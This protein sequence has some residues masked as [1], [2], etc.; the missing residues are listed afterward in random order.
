MERLKLRR[1]M[2]MAMSEPKKYLWTYELK[3]IVFPAELALPLEK[4]S[5][6]FM[7][8]NLY[9]TDPSPSNV[10]P[11]N[12]TIT[13]NVIVTGENLMKIEPVN[14]YD[15]NNVDVEYTDDGIIINSTGQN[16][17]VTYKFSG[18]I[19]DENY[20]LDLYGNSV[21]NNGD[22]CGISLKHYS[23]GLAFAENALDDAPGQRYFK[24][25]T[26]TE[27]LYV[28]FKTT[29]TATSATTTIGEF[30]LR[31]IDSLDSETPPYEPYGTTYT[32]DFDSRY[33]NLYG[34]CV[35]LVD[36]AVYSNYAIA[37]IDSVDTYINNFAVSYI[38][39]PEEYGEIIDFN[40]VC[41][42]AKF[43]HS[44]NYLNPNN[45]F[46]DNVYTIGKVYDENVGHNR[47]AIVF[48][49]ADAESV[50]DYNTILTQNKEAVMEVAYKFL[51][52]QPFS[53]SQNS[54]VIVPFIGYN[55][56]YA[57]TGGGKISHINVEYWN[58][59]EQP[60]HIDV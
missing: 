27:D 3:H 49:F 57:T 8:T 23:S 56:I 2:M 31:R 35:N 5:V 46:T 43:N 11:I 47:D 59:T 28:T 45:A 54:N 15:S 21:S 42:M 10:N 53:P 1:R 40:S 41:N 39:I 20:V 37:S 38:D 52:P 55:N 16:A 22:A 24:F 32:V 34:G 13:M 14:L 12:R 60:S 36:G 4:L 58:N 26:E 30:Q 48:T 51:T 9:D 50:E 29:T 7:P 17:Y 33:N 18:L 25:F 44:L 6:F 19:L